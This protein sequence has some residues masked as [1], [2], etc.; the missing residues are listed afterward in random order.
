MIEFTND[1]PV[2]EVDP[3]MPKLEDI[4]ENVSLDH[5]EEMDLESFDESE[6]PPRTRNPPSYLD[7]YVTEEMLKKKNN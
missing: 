1:V 5:E 4:S 6:L 3:K 2:N 7:D